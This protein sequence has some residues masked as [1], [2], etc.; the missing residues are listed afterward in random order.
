MSIHFKPGPDDGLA[1]DL[2]E[3]LREEAVA[4]AGDFENPV[5]RQMIAPRV[6]IEDLRIN[7]NLDALFWGLEIGD[8][9]T[10]SILNTF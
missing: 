4:F 6:A 1:I 8:K 5:R 2:Y 10:D 9:V 7:W 3:A